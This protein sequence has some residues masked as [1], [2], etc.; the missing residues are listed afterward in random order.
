MLIKKVD[1][2][3]VQPLGDILSNL[4]RTP[5]LNHVQLSTSALRLSTRRG[6]HEQSVSHLSFEFVLLD[7]VCQSGRDF[8]GC[9]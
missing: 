5:P 3:A 1:L 7:V 6:T 8:P 2:P 4:M 9:C